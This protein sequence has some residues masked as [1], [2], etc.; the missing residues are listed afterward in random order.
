MP[1]TA[2]VRR[3]AD[4]AAICLESSKTLGFLSN[5]AQYAFCYE[6]SMPRPLRV[7]IKDLSVHV[8]HRGINRMQIFDDEEDHALFLRLI[9]HGTKQEGVDVHGFS[10]MNNHYHLQATPKHASALAG[11]MRR[12]HS[13]YSRYYNRKHQRTGTIW[14]L[15]PRVVLIEDERQWLTCLRYIEQNPVRARL[16]SQPEDY[17]WS[18]YRLHALGEPM[19]WL[20]PHPVYLALG[21]TA[22]ARQA[23][24]AAICSTPVTASESMAQRGALVD[25][26]TRETTDP[27]QSV[28]ES[29]G[30][31]VTQPNV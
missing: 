30:E 4:S 3:I 6:R 28:P 14:G 2:S 27:A 20:V 15:R 9:R 10:L 23:A 13:A 29:L 26:K 31:G 17:R 16:V 24:Y 5:T 12:I 18:S 8:M 22:R 7:Y 1:A 21:A 19:S 11:A 25:R